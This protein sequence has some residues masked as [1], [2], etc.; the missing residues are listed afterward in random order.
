MLK[1]GDTLPSFSLPNQHDVIVS[2]DKLKGHWVVL[3]FYPKDN[4]PGC[5]QE[6]CDFRD[7]YNKLK[8]LG[9][10]V[11]GISKDSP[12]SHTNFISKYALPFDLLSDGDGQICESFGVWIEKS[13]YGRKYFGIERSTF[14]I[15][16]DGAIAHIW[17]KVSVK[18]HVTN[19]IRVLTETL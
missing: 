13:M 19:V 17:R 12:K 5:T 15:T 6:S 3:Y 7:T 14:L 9:C 18:D 1:T 10:A 8:E 16:P 2:S 4:T 11:L